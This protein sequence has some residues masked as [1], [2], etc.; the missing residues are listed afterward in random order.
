[1]FY[2][3]LKSPP[4]Y[5]SEEQYMVCA[6]KSFDYDSFEV[7]MTNDKGSIFA[8]TLD[9]ARRMIPSHACRLPFEPQ[10]QFLELWEE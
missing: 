1:M 3:I 5:A 6:Y 7:S 8:S 2:R 9:D 4:G 10:A